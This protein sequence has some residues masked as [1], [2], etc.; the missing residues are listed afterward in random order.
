MKYLNKET[1]T[2]TLVLL[3][4]SH[5]TLATTIFDTY[6]G[7][8]DHGYG[9]VIGDSTIFDVN[10]IS[11]T[12]A[13]NILSVTIDTNFA[14]YGDNGLFASHTLD[15]TGI[16]YGDLLIS[17]T[18]NPVGV[19][20]YSTDSAA[21]GTVWQYGY[22]LDNRW[23]NENETG[24]G[25]LYSLNSGDNLLDTLGSDHFMTGATF[26]NGQEIAV[27]TASNTTDLLNSN[28]GWDIGSGS[29]NMSIDLTGTTLLGSD[30]IAFHWGP[31]C[32]ND[33]IEGQAP[34][35]AVPVPASIWLFG[36][37]LIGLVGVSRRKGLKNS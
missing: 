22:S 30:T 15:N 29:I 7:S 20:P 13:N 12:L 19:S 32:A 6:E 18:W 11:F 24:T 2:L 5:S 10:S 23:M 36:S 3:G 34:L 1:I 21:N 35:A 8:E 4:I 16:G 28:G 26:R 14:G 17:S 9:D 33:I 31:S 27:N 37:G 25:A